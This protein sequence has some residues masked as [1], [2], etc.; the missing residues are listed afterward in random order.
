LEPEEFFDYETA[1][2]A[3]LDTRNEGLVSILDGYLNQSPAG[4][5]EGFVEVALEDLTT[6]L[7][8][9]N[10]NYEDDLAPAFE[11]GFELMYGMNDPYWFD[12]NQNLLITVS[13]SS[14]L[15]AVIDKMAEFDDYSKST[16]FGFNTFTN[17]KEQIYLA[18]TSD[19]L[20]AWPSFSSRY[21]SLQSIKNGEQN[22]LQNTN[23]T[24]YEDSVPYP[25]VGSFYF[26]M[27]TTGESGIFA[28]V[29]DNEGL[30]L[31]YRMTG[32]GNSASKPP[33]MYQNLPGNDILIY[34]ENYGFADRSAE[35]DD[36]TIAEMKNEGII[37]SEGE[38]LN[39]GFALLI[40]DTESL[41]P[42]ISYYF[43]ATGYLPQAEDD[44]E[45][46]NTLVEQTITEMQAEDPDLDGLI[47]KDTVNVDG[48]NLH[49]VTVDIASLPQE[50]LAELG[51]VA[52]FFTTPVEFYYGITSD[53]YVVIALYSG[54]DSVYG[55]VPAISEN[56]SV[57]EGMNYVEDYPNG[58]GYV[59]VNNAV[60]YINDIISALEENTE[61]M[62]ADTKE[63]YNEFMSYF[64]IVEYII[65]GEK[66]FAEFGGGLMFIK[67]N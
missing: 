13:D 36:D 49:R 22:L 63:S 5:A 53:D 17:E 8:K 46:F 21:L 6:E 38:W 24:Q 1:F 56:Q 4:D 54:F 25:N 15:N 32:Y 35:L 61:P 20:V 37:V 43:D 7:S 67:I 9:A 50:E 10:L 57:T 3:V 58:L 48:A 12:Q 31:H 40:Q 19:V 27:S 45:A 11:G 28:L 34:G 62:P 29:P 16:L 59:S 55:Q 47:T 33:Y 18:Y 44:V 52:D 26:N 60:N 64:D 2:F 42:G 23:Y 65:T 30:K 41:I 14:A 66:E 39:K 51:P